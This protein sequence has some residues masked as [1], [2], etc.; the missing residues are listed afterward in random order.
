M[1]L[2]LS[3]CSLYRQAIVASMSAGEYRR[4]LEATVG[5]THEAL[6]RPDYDLPREDVDFVAASQLRYLDRERELLVSRVGRGSIVEGHGDLRPEHVCIEDQPQIIDCLEFSQ[7]LRIQ[8]CAD[9]L[10]FLAL[11]CERL[12]APALRQTIFASYAALADDPV[13]P[14]LVDFYQSHR[15]YLRAKIAARHLDDAPVRDPERWRRQALDYLRLARAHV[16]RC[17]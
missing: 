14:M 5:A 9:E 1:P 15:A 10:A 16:V 11:E 6:S 2:S 17:T 7:D 12:G 13:P 4:R 8:D 3:S